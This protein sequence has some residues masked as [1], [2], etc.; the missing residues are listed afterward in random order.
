[1]SDERI[2]VVGTGSW[3]TT[4]AIL[5]SQKGL[6][7][8]LWARDEKERETLEADRENRTFLSGFPFQLSEVF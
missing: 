6:K 1:M 4:L 3:G 2:A 8:A 5:L 7:V